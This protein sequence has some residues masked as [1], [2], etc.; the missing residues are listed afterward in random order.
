MIKRKVT[1]RIL[2]PFGE[3]LHTMKETKVL[4]LGAGLGGLS[5][6]YYLDK[7]I[8]YL[9]CEKE[10][11][12]GGLCRTFALN[13]F[14]F[15]LTGHLL[16]LQS[17]EIAQLLFEQLTIPFLSQKR[18][19][20][21]YIYNKYIA[22]PFQVNTYGLPAEVIYECVHE[23]ITNHYK[24]KKE[25]PENFKD[26]L[27][28]NFGKGISK[29]FMF[30]YNEKLWQYPLSKMTTEWVWSIPQPEI[31]DVLKGALGVTDK[32]YGYNPIFY[33]PT[34]GGIETL[35]QAMASSLS[36]IMLNYEATSI[37]Y[38]NKIVHFANGETI[39]YEYLVSTIALKRF[40]HQLS[41]AP[42]II[43]ENADHLK[44]VKVINFNIGINKANVTPYHWIYFPEQDFVFYRIG[45]STNYCASIAPPKTTSM[46]IEISAKEHEKIDLDI[47]QHQVIEGLLKLGFISSELDILAVHRAVINPAYVIFDKKRMRI[48]TK[49]K[50]F[51]STNH[52]CTAGRFGNWNYGSMEAA[53]LE[54]KEIAH[55]LNKIL[56]V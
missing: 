12:A 39:K 29:H 16:H 10:D 17:D 40:L 14:L 44:C 54:G 56:G 52:I 30:P 7:S 35:P 53:L 2:Y 42:R 36:P 15:D 37:D 5:T 13:G 55:Q 45:F 31:E 3:V 4:I 19:S 47:A 43:Y 38:K 20:A 51:L 24:R 18:K 23:F 50:R 21:I 46:Y 22:Y 49:M 26:W 33:Y 32:L 27:L 9:I 34:H 48:L 41:N 25:A 11:R 1:G 6:A 8:P 28:F